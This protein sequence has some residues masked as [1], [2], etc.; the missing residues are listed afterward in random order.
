MSSFLIE[1]VPRCLIK[2]ISVAVPE[3]FDVDPY[4]NFDIVL[5]PDPNVSVANNSNFSRF[6]F[7]FK[8]ILKI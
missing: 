1:N 6:H 8:Q 5:D 4:A 2:K 3:W 7:L